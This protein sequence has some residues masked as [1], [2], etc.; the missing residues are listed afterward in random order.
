MTVPVDISQAGTL[1]SG[2]P[3]VLFETSSDDYEPSPDG[4]RFLLV[5]S[6]EEN[7]APPATVVLN[8][9]EVLKRLVPTE[10]D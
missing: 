8:W 9:F 10:S 2:P 3:R 5:E 7:N 1:R 6:T 4:Q